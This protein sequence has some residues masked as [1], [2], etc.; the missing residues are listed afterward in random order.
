MIKITSVRHHRNGVCGDP[1]YSMFIHDG[2]QKLA[3]IITGRKGGCYVVDDRVLNSTS[4]G[5]DGYRGDHYEPYCRLAI[6]KQHCADFGYTPEEA[7]KE[8]NECAGEKVY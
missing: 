7:R 1:F 6:V 4:P 3:A 8:L 2:D 5:T